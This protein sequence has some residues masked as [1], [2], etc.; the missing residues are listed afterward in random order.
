MRRLYAIA[1]LC[2]ALLL[3][4][5]C[6]FI[7][8]TPTPIP[9]PT[10]TATS[11]PTVTAEAATSTPT[12]TA[13]WTPFPSP[14]PTPEPTHRA[15]LGVPAGDTYGIRGTAVDHNRGLLYVLGMT[16][17]ASAGQGV[18]TV[19]DLANG[20]VRTSVPLPAAFIEAPQVTLSADG[21][22]LYCTDSGGS[23]GDRLLV[24]STGL[25][26]EPLGTILGDVSDVRAVALDTINNRL[27]VTDAGVLRRLHARTLA[28]EVHTELPPTGAAFSVA[29]L[30]VNRQSGLLY[31]TG[32]D[33]ESVAVYRLEDLR[34]EAGLAPGGRIQTILSAPHR[35]QT[36]VLVEHLQPVPFRRVALIQGA[37]L[38]AQS[39]E[40]EP[41]WD[42]GQIAFDSESG[43]LL[44]L[45]DSKGEEQ[46]SRI[47]VVESE[48]GQVV[49][50]VETPYLN[51]TYPGYP[52]VA[53]VHRG[54]LYS[55][56]QGEV[57]SETLVAIR[58]QTGEAVEPIHLGIRLVNAAL[59]EAT[60]RLFVLDSRGAV[61]VLNT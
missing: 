11:S 10:I 13:T 48:S 23:Q 59:D 42:I 32:L 54:V 9:T 28:E 55:W 18:L 24:V 12:P 52:H 39:W 31:A 34:Q 7:F 41:G 26:T 38:S 53:F 47:R 21:M 45:E 5:G 49:Q 14:T 6:Q 25:G 58:M 29:L 46:R 56:R 61:R 57:A 16:G 3:A 37:R 60:G 17:D 15:D 20:Q 22:R 40:P 1:S 36:Y 35:D 33:S 8:K 19:V 50:T 30:V 27:Y 2:L 44:L 43:N 4:T 51:W